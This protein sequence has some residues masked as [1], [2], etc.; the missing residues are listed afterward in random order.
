MAD[1]AAAA[2]DPVEAGVGVE[3]PDAGSSWSLGRLPELGGLISATYPRETAPGEKGV[4]HDRRPS[5]PSGKGAFDNAS[6]VPLPSIRKRGKQRGPGSP[7]ASLTDIRGD[8]PAPVPA[9][10]PAQRRLH[11]SQRDQAPA[12]P[13]LPASIVRGSPR[14]SHQPRSAPL[15]TRLKLSAVTKPPRTFPRCA[16]TGCG[17]RC[18]VMPSTKAEGPFGET[19][20]G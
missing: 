13:K 14:A 8:T 15:E 19:W 5:C 16:S 9:P 10:S 17:S 3:D 18:L 12:A 11:A 2:P 20:G 4:A 7:G 1:R 6:P